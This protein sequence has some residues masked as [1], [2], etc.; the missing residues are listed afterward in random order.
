MGHN[1]GAERLRDLARGPG[2]LAQ[3]LR[4][5]RSLDG[6]DLVRKARCGLRAMATAQRDRQGENRR[7]R[8]D[9]HLAG[10]RAAVAVLC[11]G[12]SVRQRRQVAQRMS[13]CAA[14][15]GRGGKGMGPPPLPKCLHPT[16]SAKTKLRA[17][18]LRYAPSFRRSRS[19]IMCAISGNRSG[20]AVPRAR[21]LARLPQLVVARR[22]GIFGRIA[23]RHQLGPG[24]V[25]DGKAR[26]IDRLLDPLR[27]GHAADG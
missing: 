23:E 15:D 6:L 21:V 25:R 17:A 2:R 18:T 24:L 19:T 4:I 9:R 8:Q 7:K 1:R 3:A 16:L 22:L 10:R 5:D 11:S 26:P 14:A 13:R 12:Q 20:P 27:L